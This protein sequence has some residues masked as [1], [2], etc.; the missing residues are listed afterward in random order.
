M[1]RRGQRFQRSADAGAPGSGRGWS[2]VQ[3]SAALLGWAGVA[4]RSPTLGGLR[5][6]VGPENSGG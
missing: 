1:A 5:V 2:I 4:D 3:R 6:A